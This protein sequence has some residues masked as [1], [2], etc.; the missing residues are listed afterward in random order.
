MT[1]PGFIVLNMLMGVT[2]CYSA[3]VQ[4]RNLQ[5]PLFYNRYFITL[6]MTELFLLLPMGLYYI[7]FYPDWS[8]MYLIHTGNSAPGISLMI[9]AIYPV[10]ATL[11]YLVGY[12]SARSQSDWVMIMFTVFLSIGLLGL[13]VIGADKLGNLGTYDQYHNNV[14]LKPWTDTSLFPSVI[15][16]SIGLLFGWGWPLLR[17]WKEGHFHMAHSHR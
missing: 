2:L 6:L 5:R 15:L 13:M 3:R 10:S 9:L 1:I 17:F 7:T 12:L 11:G 8:W 16:S 14:N 4:I